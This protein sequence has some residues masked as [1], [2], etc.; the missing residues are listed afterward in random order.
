[1]SEE[2]KLPEPSL[3][4]LVSNSPKNHTVVQIPVSNMNP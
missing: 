2:N 1:M 4:K 3:E